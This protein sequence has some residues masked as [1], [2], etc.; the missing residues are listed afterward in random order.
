[1]R[2][3]SSDRAKAELGDLIALDTLRT[4]HESF[5]PKLMGVDAALA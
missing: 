2:E 1:M 4:A 3:M 5:F